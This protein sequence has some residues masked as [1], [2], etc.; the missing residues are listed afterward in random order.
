MQQAIDCSKVD[1]GLCCFMALLS[2]NELKYWD[3]LI[4]SGQFYNN[5]M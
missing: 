1:Q 4:Q 5:K 2:L 3:K